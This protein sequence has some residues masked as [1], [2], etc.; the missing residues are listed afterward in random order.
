MAS[1]LAKELQEVKPAQARP[2]ALP[3][4]DVR[5]GKPGLLGNVLRFETV[6]RASRVL[7]LAALDI[8][9]LFLAI[10]TALVIKTLVVSPEHVD[11]TFDQTRDVAPLACLVLLLLFAR[12]GLYRDRSQRPGFATVIASLVQL[13]LVIL[14]YAEIEGEKFQSY[15]IFYGSLFFGL[16]YLSSFRWLFGRVS[17]AVLRAAG[18]RRR[19]V[20]VGS[21][22]HIEAVAHA[23]KDSSEIEPFGFVAGN[24]YTA[25]GLQDFRSLELLERHFDAVDE[26]L[27]TDPDFPQDEAVDRKSTRLNSSH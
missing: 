17:G 26:V 16:I 6:R 4:R 22:A 7:T 12:S 23:L 8:A 1:G 20:L 21:G 24:S 9:G 27:I 18:Y 13:T 10:W 2:L 19:A 5:A 25:N 3:A 11:R 15:Y 14:V